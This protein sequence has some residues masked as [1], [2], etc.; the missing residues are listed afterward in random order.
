[1]SQST[2]LSIFEI[3]K[4]K[5]EKA[6]EDANM[7]TL[8]VWQKD[9][10]IKE[11][12]DELSGIGM[13]VFSASLLDDEKREAEYKRLENRLE[14]LKIEKKD[15]LRSLG[16]SENYTDVKYECEK[17]SDT[18]Y[19]G[20]K[21]CDC[22]K[23]TITERNYK[24]S[25]IGKHLE[26]QTFE[27]F[28]FSYYQD[29]EEKESMK[30]IYKKVKEYAENF[31]ENTSESLLFVGGTGLGK[32]HLSSAL[33][34]TVIKKGFSVCYDSAQNILT[35]FEKDRFLR[36]GDTPRS[37]KYLEC[38]LLVIDDLGA[39]LQTKSSVSHFYTLINT[40]LISS[41]P[42]VIS[43]NLDAPQLTSHYEQRIVS[44][45]FGEYSVHH[46]RGRD[47]RLIKVTNK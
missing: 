26:T 30:N 10:R 4:N 35:A 28:S 47:I 42:V 44:R 29:G 9:S 23:K 46:F 32:T 16:Y 24:T 12:D 45:F 2:D 7:R 14:L 43:T 34:K 6:R 15:R 31:N 20:I 40:R 13:S 33:A 5:A 25:G 41:K 3:Y 22:L 17:C 27:N 39:E 38:D 37:D 36:E 18:G 11:I 8:E 1:M 21:M 19:V